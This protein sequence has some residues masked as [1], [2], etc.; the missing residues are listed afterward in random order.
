MTDETRMPPHNIQAEQS[1]LG[2]MLI[3]ADAAVNVM[4]MLTA[5]HF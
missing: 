4:A 3:S 2:G 5:D 1:V